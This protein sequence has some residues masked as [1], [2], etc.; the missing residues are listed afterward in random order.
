MKTLISETK[1]TTSNLAKSVPKIP[2]YNFEFVP[3]PLASG[4]VA[5]FI[6]DRHSYRI[7][8]KASNEAFQALWVEISF[9]KKKNINPQALAFFLK[10]GQIPWGGDTEA[11]KMPGLG[12]KKED[13]C[14][15]PGIINFQH[16]CRC[17][18]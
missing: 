8:E 14:S 15:A 16:L 4:G 11:V 17:F 6:D 3:T 18:Y 1:I 10:T 7:L 5:L 9:V 13:K 12:T 2:G